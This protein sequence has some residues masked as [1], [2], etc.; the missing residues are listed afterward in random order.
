MVVVIMTQATWPN[1]QSCR[2]FLFSSSHENVS[3]SVPYVVPMFLLATDCMSLSYLAL[4][5]LDR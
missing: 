4:I 5:W 2:L 3:L 1:S